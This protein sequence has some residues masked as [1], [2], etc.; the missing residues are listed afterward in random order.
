LAILLKI[1]SPIFFIKS[2]GL[3]SNAL[4][5]KKLDFKAIAYIDILS[6]FAGFLA[7]IICIFLSLGTL[8]VVISIGITCALFSILSIY[9]SS[10]KFYFSIRIKFKEIDRILSYSAFQSMN[11]L[12]NYFSSQ[13]DS[14]VIGKVLGMEVLGIYAYIK[15]LLFKPTLQVVNLIFNKMLFPILCSYE[16]TKKKGSIYLETVCVISIIN[17]TI[18]SLFYIFGTFILT[19]VFGKD[20]GSNVDILNMMIPYVL[21]ISL[22]N[23]VG[24]L[25]KATGK[26]KFGFYWDL[27]ISGFRCVIIYYAVDNGILTLLLTLNIFMFVVFLVH[28]Y[29]ILRKKYDIK[30]YDWMASN[31]EALMASFCIFTL[32]YG[33]NTIADLNFQSVGVFLAFIFIIAA[34]L[35][36]YMISRIFKIGKN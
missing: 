9:F 23:P 8:S 18:Y 3:Q 4:S 36:P 27:I 2:L 29:F 34:I 11:S 1:I 14:I 7:L 32:Y 21:F 30:L 20:W 15:D 31:I 19:S 10:E 5:Q 13:F 35:G 33:S 24:C 28:F 17:I 25:L 16:S 12:F 22:I 6:T 26:V